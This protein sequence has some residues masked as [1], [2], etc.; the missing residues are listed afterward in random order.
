MK[1]VSFSQTYG[2]ERKLLLECQMKDKRMIELKNLFDVNIFSFHNC[3]SD[4]IKY[5][6]DINIVKNSRIE[7]INT[8]HYRDTV[9][10]MKELVKELDATHFFFSQ[11]DTFSVDNIGVDWNEVLDYVKSF[12]KN[13]VLSMHYDGERIDP[14]LKPDIIGETIKIYQID[15]KPYVKSPNVWM[16]F[17]DTAYICTVDMLDVFYEENYFIEQD[18]W[19]CEHVLNRRANNFE[20]IIENR[21]ALDR[22]MFECHNIFGRHLVNLDKHY[23]NMVRLGLLPKEYLQNIPKRVTTSLKFDNKY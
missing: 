16:G 21:H 6:K 23:K 20:L 18:V 3:P 13:F 10:R 7:I 11:D 5:F 12:D 19:D 1:L 8:K 22:C 2:N 4:T 14:N 17:D 15:N 9:K